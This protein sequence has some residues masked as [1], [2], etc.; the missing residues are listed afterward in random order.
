MLNLKTPS[1]SSNATILITEV[2]IVPSRS[3]DEVRLVKA[4]TK[5][6]EPITVV[7]KLPD[8]KEGDI[9]DVYILTGD[10]LNPREEGCYYIE[11]CIPAPQNFFNS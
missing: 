3:G 8:V 7:D 5:D 4:V 9:L 11:T 10:T 2:A 1:T 6:R